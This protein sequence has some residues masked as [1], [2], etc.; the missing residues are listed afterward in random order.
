MDRL[1]LAANVQ[2]VMEHIPH[3]SCLD[4]PGMR[5]EQVGLAEVLLHP[6]QVEKDAGLGFEQAEKTSVGRYFT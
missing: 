5:A 6:G 4:G 3:R 2:K 1:M